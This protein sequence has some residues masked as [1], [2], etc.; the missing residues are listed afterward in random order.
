MTGAPQWIAAI[1]LG[2][3]FLVGFLLDGTPRTDPNWDGTSLMAGAFMWWALLG[4]GG[5]WK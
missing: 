1:S 3:Q 4:L 5:F 2:T